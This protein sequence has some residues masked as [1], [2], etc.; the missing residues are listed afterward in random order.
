[1]TNQYKYIFFIILVFSGSFFIF[2][3]LKNPMYSLTESP[4]DAFYYLTYAREL[5]K[6]NLFSWNG[7]YPSTGFHPLWLFL[8]AIPFLFTP[9]L[10]LIVAVLSIF[11]V[12]C[13]LL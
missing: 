1:M 12:G 10:I 9:N 7:I 6:G 4:D 11:L 8:T 2:S 3:F 5:A 13:F